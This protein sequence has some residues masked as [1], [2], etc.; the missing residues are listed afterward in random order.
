[1]RTDPHQH[2]RCETCGR[3]VDTDLDVDR[4]E[5]PGCAAPGFTVAAIDVIVHG[6]CSGCAEGP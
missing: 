6:H 1:V 5:V 3:I 2:L 4:L